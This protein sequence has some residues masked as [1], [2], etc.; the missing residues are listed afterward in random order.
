VPP[1]PP[2]PTPRINRKGRLLNEHLDNKR[3]AVELDYAKGVIKEA[4]YQRQ[5][6]AVN[7]ARTDTQAVINTDYRQ[8]NTENQ[9]KAAEEETETARRTTAETKRTEEAKQRI[10]EATLQSA[11][12]YTDTLILLF[13]EESTAGQAALAL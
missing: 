1:P 2:V 9:K 6:A 5:L 7:K 4:E 12:N 8:S 3:Q 13:G 11:Q 10:K